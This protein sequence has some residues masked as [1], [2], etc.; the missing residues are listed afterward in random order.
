MSICYN[1]SEKCS[2]HKMIL[3]KINEEDARTKIEDKVLQ[4]LLF[5]EKNI[6]TCA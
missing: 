6:Y 3:A 5:N 1:C 4:F 2:F